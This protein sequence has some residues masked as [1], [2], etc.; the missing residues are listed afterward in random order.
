[1]AWLLIYISTP[2]VHGDLGG[3]AQGIGAVGTEALRRFRHRIGSV[4]VSVELEVPCPDGSC[5]NKNGKI[6]FETVPVGHKEGKG[7]WLNIFCPE[8]SCL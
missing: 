4:P 7:V 8:D 3:A 5:M 6:V 1:L 2:R